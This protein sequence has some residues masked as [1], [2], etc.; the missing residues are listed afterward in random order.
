MSVVFSDYWIYDRFDVCMK[1]E[2]WSQL[3][4]GHQAEYRYKFGEPGTEK[5]VLSVMG[6]FQKL[7]FGWLTY[8]FGL[9]AV[10]IMLAFVGLLSYNDNIVGMTV[11]LL[12]YILLAVIMMTLGMITNCVV[13]VVIGLYKNIV[14]YRWMKNKVK[15]LGYMRNRRYLWLEEK[16]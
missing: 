7:L 1:W 12:P 8:I 6:N 2:L 3:T 9:Y 5:R 13:I 4:E 16:R 11:K 15:V 10:F 14:M